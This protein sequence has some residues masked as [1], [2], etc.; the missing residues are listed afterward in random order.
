M[1]VTTLKDLEKLIKLCRTTGIESMTIGELTFKLGDLPVTK[2][3]RK[4]VE[5]PMDDVNHIYTPGGV[6]EHTKIQTPDEL[7]DEQILMWSSA[8]GGIQSGESI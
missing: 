3:Q 5:Y 8:P 7:S 2:K 4:F 6:D 1:T